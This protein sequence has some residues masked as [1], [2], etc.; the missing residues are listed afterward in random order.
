MAARIRGLCEVHAGWCGPVRLTR[1]DRQGTAPRWARWG[2][3]GRDRA[4]HRTWRER[5]PEQLTGIFRARSNDILTANALATR[6][7]RAGDS[8]T[9]R[10]NLRMARL[11]GGNQLR[12][13]RVASVLRFPDVMFH[14]EFAHM[15]RNWTPRPGRTATIRI[16]ISSSIITGNLARHSR[17]P[18][19]KPPSLI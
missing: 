4:G 11:I 16:F 10:C 9:V 17:K 15:G 19:S 8:T 18:I 3:L 2:A 7:R 14:W 6:A 13:Q 1:A 5:R 12:F